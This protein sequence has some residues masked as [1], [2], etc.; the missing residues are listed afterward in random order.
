MKDSISCR[1]LQIRSNHSRSIS[2]HRAPFERWVINLVA[3][4]LFL[5]IEIT[6]PACRAELT[7]ARAIPN[8]ARIRS[9]IDG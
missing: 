3:L 4:S 2:S 8:R 6:K 9:I 7:G 5:G 1:V